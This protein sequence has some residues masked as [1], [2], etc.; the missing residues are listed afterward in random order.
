MIVIVGKKSCSKCEM[1]K[2]LLT[3][4][5]IEFNYIDIDSDNSGKLLDRV[6]KENDSHYPMILKDDKVVSLKDV[7]L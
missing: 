3:K 7:L 2:K 6:I 1:V 5:S 4:R